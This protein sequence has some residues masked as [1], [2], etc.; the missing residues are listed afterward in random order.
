MLDKRGWHQK[1]QEH[2][3]CMKDVNL[4]EEMS[5]LPRQEDPEEAALKWLALAVLHG[6]NA[7][8]EKISL[9]IDNQGVVTASA[10]YREATLPSPGAEI[11][12]KIVEAVRAVTHLEGDKAK[13]PLALGLG[14]DNLTLGIKIKEEG[15]AKKISLKFP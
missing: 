8:A 11:G 9:K 10:I 12:A 1:V 15:G 14:N 5:L 7:G 6:I 4:L 2:M 13:G 3:D